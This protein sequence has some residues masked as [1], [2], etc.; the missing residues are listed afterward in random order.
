MEYKAYTHMPDEYPMI[1]LDKRAKGYITILHDNPINVGDIFNFGAIPKTEP[2]KFEIRTVLEIEEQREAR[3][4]SG[5]KG[6]KPTFY[7]LKLS[8]CQ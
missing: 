6:I 4:Q 5:Y 2:P 1:Q 8:P 7:K 3:V